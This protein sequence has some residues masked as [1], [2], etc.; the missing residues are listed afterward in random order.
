LYCVILKKKSVPKKRCVINKNVA[1]A[2][3]GK[4]Y[5]LHAVCGI[6]FLKG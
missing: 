4:L 5:G 1:K 2:I 3:V 6:S